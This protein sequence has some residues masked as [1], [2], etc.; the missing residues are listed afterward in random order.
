V[1]A[2]TQQA[3]LSLLN[4]NPDVLTC[5]ANL[6]NDE[7][8]TPPQL[9]NQMLDM[10]A[11]AW[12]KDHDGASIWSDSSLRFLDPF[13]KSGV[14]LREIT[15]RLIE[16]LKAEIPDLVQRVDHILTK[17]VF[18]IG[19]TQLTALIARRSLYCS[20]WADGKHSVATSFDNADGNVWFESM[21]HT[22][23]GGTEWVETAD[24]QGNPIKKYTNGRCRYCGASQKSL[25]RSEGLETHAYAFIHTDDIR[26]RIAELFGDDMQFDVIIG[27]PPYQLGDGGGGGGASATPIY[28]LFVE[29]ALSLDPRYVV[30]I[31]PSRWFSGGK[32]LDDFRD[33]M[34]TDHH[35]VK[36]IDHPQLYDVFPGVKIR[37]GVSYWIWSADH[38]GPCEVVTKIGDDIIGEPAARMLDA[39]DVLVRRNEAVRVLD[40]VANFRVGG[41]PEPKLG[42]EVS[43]RKPF[44]LTNQRGKSTPVGVKDPVLVYGNQIR[45][46]M[47]R[48]AITS[49]PAWIDKWK[50]L[51]VKAHGTSGRDDVTI[52]GE[53][54]VAGPASACT[55]TYLVIGVFDSEEEA[56]NLAAY[57][58]T[59]FV[60]FLVSLRKITQNI[61]RDS[62]LFVPKL[63]MD[64]VW[65]DEALFE[66][67][68]INRHQ[69]EF[70]ESLIADRPGDEAQAADEDPDE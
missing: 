8:F 38:D 43:A 28:N 54:V 61:T 65:T 7:V 52:L 59:R 46:Y 67:Y 29:K 49:N 56:R 60:R 32:G 64:R 47:E 66:R 19:I 37:G 1:A 24:A 68:A 17:Q 40:R 27:N 51:L 45:S 3:G 31:T 22:W 39:Y 11:D 13:T 12:A 53:P 16:G 23:V 69:V 55:E 70:I 4:R 57:M 26:A 2:V 15:T 14:F 50:V 5:I 10:I 41:A 34:L 58:R 63:P 30:M 6:S 25:D 35:F 9:A 33:R 36:L 42:N 21:D 48:S 44:G 18:G 20:K 62:Y